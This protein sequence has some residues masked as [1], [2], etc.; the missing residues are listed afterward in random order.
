MKYR[1][2]LIIA[3]LRFSIFAFGY[4][5][6]IKQGNVVAAKIE[7][8]KIEKGRLPDSLSEIGIVETE[9]GPIYYKKES[10]SKYILWFG[11]ELG[12]SMTYDSDEKQWK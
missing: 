2:F 11:K 6:K 8:F 1:Y 4:G 10:E 5:E 3:M 12:E 9:S 7:K